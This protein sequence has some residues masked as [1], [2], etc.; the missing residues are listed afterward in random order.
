MKAFAFSDIHGQGKLFKQIMDYLNSLDEDFSCFCL[1]DACDRGPDGYAIMKQL[2]AAD[3]NRFTYL[4]GNH[5][6]MFVA[7]A[8]EFIEMAE[9]EGYSPRAYAEHLRKDFHLTTEEIL[10][11]GSDMYL[12]LH[13]GGLPTFTDWLNDG[14][15]MSIVQQLDA[16]EHSGVVEITDADNNRV[17]VFDMCHAGCSSEDWNDEAKDGLLWDRNHF[18]IKWIAE[19]NCPHVLL[20]GHTPVSLMPVEC[21]KNNDMLVDKILKYADDTKVDLDLGCFHFH[22]ACLYN[23]IDDEEIYFEDIDV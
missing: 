17:K 1:G 8:N 5:E 23:F 22:I 14:C 20:H 11:T 9:D 10:F 3:P 6:D 16:L 12:Y 18:H 7:A 2:L 4:K 15:P 19:D 21:R 13:N